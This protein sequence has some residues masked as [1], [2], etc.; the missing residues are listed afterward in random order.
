MSSSSN[1]SDFDAL[2]ADQGSTMVEEQPSRRS[3]RPRKRKVGRTVLI[4][5]VILVLLAVVGVGGYAFYVAN[6][7][8]SGTTEIPDEEAFGGQRPEPSGEGQNILLLGSDSR[9][10]DEG[11]DD[12]QGNRSDTIMVAHIPADNSG[13]QM[14]SIPRD[15]W[16]E[17][18]GHGQAKINA[19]MSYGGVSL[20]I[21]TVS[22]F[23]GAPIHNVALIDFEG[24]EALTN[25]L[26]GVTVNSSQAF[27]AGGFDFQEGPNDLTGEQALAFV[28]ERKSFADG[29]LQRMRNQQAFLNGIMDEIISADTL[30]NP[31]KVA[32]M[33]RDFSPYM[34][35]D[36][37]LSSS[38]LVSMALKLRSVDTSDVEFFSA[39]ISGAGRS[40]DGQEYLSV[41]E[42][43]LGELQDAFAN[44]TV[45]EYA[46]AAEDQHL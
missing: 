14:L 11:I 7:W 37:G 10:V 28:R 30:S 43:G 33:I 3:Q 39:P 17:V 32:G 29:D 41:D 4:I 20:A 15:T 16:V 35:V 26:G 42:D 12:Q 27:S 34:S 1:G 5:A 44:D 2:F 9:A 8:D 21:S 22:D 38:K 46:A 13:I 36:S 19:A 18:E 31:N 24:F 45:G 6:Q 40:S 23:I 25:S